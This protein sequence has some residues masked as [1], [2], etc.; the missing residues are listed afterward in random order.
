M[1]EIDRR[2]FVVQ[3][4]GALA[5]VA[6]VPKLGLGSFT[7]AEPMRVGVIGLG[8]QGRAIIAE[9][10]GIEGVTI[11]SICDTDE[12]RLKS[13]SRRARGAATTADA[14]AIFDDPSI[15]AVCIA[16]PTHLHR[17]LVEQALAAGKHVY[18]EAPIA[19]T[20]EDCRAIVRAARDASTVFQPGLFARSDPVY[21]LA[22][23]FYR[24]DA[25]R[26][27]VSMSAA[28][29]KKTSWRTPASDPARAAAL[30]WRL[31]PD[32]STG[33]A[34]EWG[35][36]QFD[37]FHWYLDRFPVAVTGRGSIRLHDDGRTIADTIACMIEFEDGAV[38]DYQATLANSYGGTWELLR[39]TN[40]A[41]RL[42]WTH[43]WL[44]KEADAPTQGWEVYAN[45]QQFHNDEGITLI[46]GATKLAEQGKLK[47]G[48]GLPHSPLRYA[49]ADFL[50][51]AAEG[52]PPPTTAA[53]ALRATAVGIIADRAVREQTT[54]AIEPAMLDA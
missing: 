48:V 51:S 45:R 10:S 47:E 8:R 36:H 9:L 30:N 50:K 18:C 39:G 17:A 38:L 31:D 52:S 13:G 24:S 43:G 2:E 42:E 1:T 32:V 35:T 33:L 49:L 15:D 41:I 6:L 29:S 27:L 34:G 14:A 46:A 3:T 37:V 40:A 25:V 4:A 12:R 44:F 19:H 26:D 22:R 28:H 54:I 20:I 11:T 21:R 16:T 7:L 23:T 5:A 53:D